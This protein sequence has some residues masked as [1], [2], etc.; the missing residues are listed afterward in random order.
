MRGKIPMRLAGI[1]L[2]ISIIFAIG[3]ESVRGQLQTSGGVTVSGN[4]NVVQGTG[5]N[6][7]VAVDSAPTTAVTGTFWQ[8]TQPVS[9]TFWQSTQPVS[10]ASL[11]ALA[12]GSSL[13][14]YTRPQNGCGTTNYEAGL[15][16]L[17]NASTSLTA[18]TTCVAYL[19]LNN[20]SGSAV[21]VTLQDQT[22]NCNSAACQILSSFSIPANSNLMMPMY[23]T[24]F[25]SGIK[26]N[27]GTA[28]AVVADVIGNQ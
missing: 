16:M 13:I 17:P 14:G 2:A 1:L 4:V 7:H 24:K 6:L 9:G 18:T 21:T 22:T 10:L 28:T 23:G 27:A 26:W 8:A 25:T 19:L 5:S 15:Q 20:T 12:A 3:S 11:P